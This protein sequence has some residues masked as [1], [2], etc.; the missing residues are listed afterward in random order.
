MRHYLANIIVDFIIE[1]KQEQRKVIRR[2]QPLPSVVRQRDG[3]VGERPEL[4]PPA[5][6]ASAGTATGQAEATG[7]GEP[8]G[9][10]GVNPWAQS[11]EEGRQ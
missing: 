11:S 10:R 7:Q 8:S 1:G 6:W 2:W 3:T 5:L 4:S 9:C